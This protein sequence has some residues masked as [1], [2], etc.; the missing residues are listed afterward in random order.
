M[1]RLAVFLCLLAAAL[2]RADRGGAGPSGHRAADRLRHHSR[3]PRRRPRRR[4]AGAVHHVAAG[5]GGAARATYYQESRS[6]MI[7]ETNPNHAAMMTGALRGSRGSPATRSRST[8]RSRTRTRARPPARRRVEV[9]I[10]RAARTPTAPRPRPSSRRSSARATPTDLLTAAIFGKPKLGRIFAGRTRASGATDHL[11][12]PCVPGGRR[13]LLRR[14]THEPGVGLRHRRP[15]GDGRGDPLDREGIGAA[16]KPA[17]RLHVREP[18]PGGQRGARAR[19]PPRRVRRGDRDGRR[20]RSSGWSPSSASA[21]SGSA[22]RSSSSP[23]TRWTR[24]RRRPT[25]GA[26]TD[27]GI[28]EDCLQIVQDGSADYVYLAERTAPGRFEL[29]KQ[30]RQIALATPG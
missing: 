2:V 24:C 12:A 10:D 15:S 14:R 20:R 25:Y 22:R 29:L 30:M 6:V 17:P 3:R 26:L 9:P 4:R 13:R 7:A 1:R 5:T 19:A 27:G 11:W 23:T 21:A 8:R 28:P 16:G 18:A